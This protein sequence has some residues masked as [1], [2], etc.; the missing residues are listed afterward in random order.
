[1]Q[2]K[3]VAE[4]SKGSYNSTIRL[5]FIKPPFIIKIFVLPILSGRFKQVL[6]YSS[7][8]TLMWPD[9]STNGLDIA[10]LSDHGPVFVCKRR[11]FSF[12]YS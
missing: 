6:L 3:S 11:R 1:M 7:V 9:V 12:V 5:T 4:C 10:D 2:V 8:F